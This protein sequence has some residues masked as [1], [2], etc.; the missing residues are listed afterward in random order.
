VADT[1]ST[2]HDGGAR[3]PGQPSPAL[4][5]DLSDPDAIARTAYEVA[6]ALAEGRLSGRAGQALMTAIRLAIE[7]R[8]PAPPPPPPPPHTGPLIRLDLSRPDRPS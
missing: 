7:A 6:V 3:A 2:D 1:S 5:I 4:N 8:K